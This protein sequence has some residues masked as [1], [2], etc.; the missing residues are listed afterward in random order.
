MSEKKSQYLDMALSLWENGVFSSLVEAYDFV[1]R[2]E[3]RDENHE[4]Q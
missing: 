3:R 2:M 1:E 4:S